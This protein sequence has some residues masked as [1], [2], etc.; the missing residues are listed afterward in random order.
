MPESLGAAVEA[1]VLAS[2]PQAEA[3]S[4]ARFI[5]EAGGSAVLAAVFFGSRKT[6]ASLDASSAYDFFVLTGSCQAFYQGLRRR[7]LSRRSPALLGLLNR[8]LPPN[9][10]SLEVPGQGPERLRAKCAV[11]S[12][13]D[14]LRASSN[15]RLDHFVLGRFCQ[16]VEI[17]YAAD[18]KVRH[19]VLAAVLSAHRLSYLWVRPWLPLE[20]DVE[21]YCRT[22]LRVSYAAEIRPEP[23]GRADALWKAQA[24]YHQPVYGALL[25]EL[26]QR[27]ELV[28]GA[29]GAYRLARHPGAGERLRLAAYFRFSKLRATARWA[30]YVITFEGWLDFI[31]G[32]A[33]RHSGQA[34]QLSERERR[35]P[36]LYLWPRVFRYLRHKDR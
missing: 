20:F 6:K 11:I 16:P 18:E 29:A 31:V 15:R 7:G 3:L 8:L 17:L 28:C 36:L 19:Q 30:K 21:T 13:A 26:E 24:A 1:R 5:A 10:I 12:L 4:A 34:I 33:S 9:Q 27:G 25:A 35:R 22:V 14:F 23:D 2:R 32:K